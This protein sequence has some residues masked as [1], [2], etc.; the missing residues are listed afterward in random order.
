M[1]EILSRVLLGLGLMFTGVLMLSSGLKQLG[2][3]SFRMFAAQSASSRSLAVLFG[4]GSGVVMQSTSAA[5]M[6]LASLISAEI[7]IVPQAIAILT[8]FSVGNSVLLFIVSMNIAVGVMFLV[9]LCGIAMYLEKDERYHTYFLIGLG[10][11]LILFG[12]EMMAAGVKPLRQEAWFAG[13]MELSRDYSLLTILA[14]AALG[15]ENAG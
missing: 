3:R 10:L 9:G 7:L 6:I 2:S 11:G 1:I 15:S 14:G 4:F 12:I 5:L 8:G 13:A